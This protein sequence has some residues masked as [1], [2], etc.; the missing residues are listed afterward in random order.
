MKRRLGRLALVVGLCAST[1]A[2]ATNASAIGVTI[3]DLED[4]GGNCDG[5]IQDPW[6]NFGTIQAH[7]VVDC[8]RN[9]TTIAIYTCIQLLAPT[10]A[11]RGL[12]IQGPTCGFKYKEGDDHIEVTGRMPIPCIPGLYH[13]TVEGI[14][15]KGVFP[16][17]KYGP[18]VIEFSNVVLIT[19]GIE[20][21]TGAEE[22]QA[23]A[24]PAEE[25]SDSS[26]GQAE[27]SAPAEE[28][29]ESEAPGEE[30]SEAEESTEAEA[31]PEESTEPEAA[32]EESSEAET[33]SEETSE[34]QPEESPQP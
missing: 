23:Q 21:N 10:F 25:S 15:T 32:P 8:N 17:Q 26:E 2:P 22:Q 3:P 9:Y 29:A 20:D 16:N 18:H 6:N 31:A 1:L 11:D 30:S 7:G 34:P 12:F 19:C 33:P 24:P 5:T 13:A 27:D 28:P 4:G 14:T